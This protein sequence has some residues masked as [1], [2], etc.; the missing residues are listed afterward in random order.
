[1]LGTG[2]LSEL[3][4]GWSVALGSPYTFQTTLES[5]F[6]TDPLLPQVAWGWLADRTGAHRGIVVLSCGAMTSAP[7]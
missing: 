7:A 2:D 6:I 4:L 3:A 1:M 5:E